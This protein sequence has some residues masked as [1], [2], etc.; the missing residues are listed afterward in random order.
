MQIPTQPD[1]NSSRSTLEERIR[2]LEARLADLHARLPA[3]SIPTAM[4]AE[5]DQL[6]EQL[7]EARQRLDQHGSRGSDAA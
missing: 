3:H 7:V 5:F 6:D 2:S 4:I 1:E